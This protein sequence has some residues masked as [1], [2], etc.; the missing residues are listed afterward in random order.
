MSG[1]PLALVEI[2]DLSN[3]LQNALKR[4]RYPLA[5][6]CVAQLG[7][8]VSHFLRQQLAGHQV[9]YPGM[10]AMA[11]WAGCQERQARKNFSTLQAAC[12]SVVHAYAKGG[13]RSTRFSV[14]FEAIVRLLVIIGANPSPE[15]IVKLRAARDR[16]RRP[17][18]DTAHRSALNPALNP[19]LNPA[20]E[21]VPSA[22][23]IQREIPRAQYPTWAVVK[24]GQRD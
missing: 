12:V 16:R 9:I 21:P 24:G 20:F 19:V 22:A 23:G 4:A 10:K 14:D 7:K 13:R 8:I 15:L 3:H 17:T 1:K 5:P 11:K 2:D 18:E 6:S